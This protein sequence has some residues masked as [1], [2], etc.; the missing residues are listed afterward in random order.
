MKKKEITILLLLAFLFTFQLMTQANDTDRLDPV[1]VT[2]EASA[3]YQE[4]SGNKRKKSPKN[5]TVQLKQFYLKVTDGAEDSVPVPLPNTRFTIRLVTKEQETFLHEGITNE[6]GEIQDVALHKIPLQGASLKISYILGNAQRGYVQKY[7]KK[8]YSFVF[9]LRL[10]N[11]NTIDFTDHQVLFGQAKKEETFFYNFQAARINYYF[12]QAVQAQADAIKQAR[13][14]FPDTANVSIKPININFEQGKYLDR[15]NAFS[16]NGH[17]NSAIPDIVV[18]DR[19]DKSF[20]TKNLMHNIMHE[21]THWNMY[22]AF[23]MPSGK[24][25]SH[26]GVNSDPKIS[27]K[28]GWAL[29]AGEVFADPESLVETDTLVQENDDQGVNRLFGQST[30]L[31]VQQVLYDLLDTGSQDEAFH[32]SERYLNEELSEQEIKQLN[33]GILYTLMMES[34]ATTLQ[35]YLIDLEDKYIVTAS[36]KEKFNEVLKINGLARDGS[37]SK[38]R[39]EKAD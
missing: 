20:E 24:Y 37:F 38:A 3:N 22:A 6:Q 39:A 36:D 1:D 25:D 13:K 31:T 9:T 4:E 17:D 32:I 35:G 21:W 8:P 18:G 2:G 5:R 15:S 7:N 27:Y 14:L 10:G 23:A 11:E 28:E 26:Y 30:N 12:D 33:F 34:E 16:R 29:F 19:S